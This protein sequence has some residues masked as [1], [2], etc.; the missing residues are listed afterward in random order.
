MKTQPSLPGREGGQVSDL[1]KENMK[2]AT[3]P[4][5]FSTRRSLIIEPT[6][7]LADNNSPS[8]LPPCREL[9]TLA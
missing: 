2:R 8:G 1:L 6:L 4:M 3:L 5:G 7:N 9:A